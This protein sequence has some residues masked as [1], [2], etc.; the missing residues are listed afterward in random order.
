M[1]FISPS[2]PF[3]LSILLGPLIAVSQTDPMFEETVIDSN[4]MTEVMYDWLE[5]RTEDT[6]I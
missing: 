4:K 6:T 2:F 5:L 3:L 1:K